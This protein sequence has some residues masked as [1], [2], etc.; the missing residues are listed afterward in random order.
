MR[1]RQLSIT[2]NNQNIELVF[3]RA[4]LSVSLRVFSRLF[5]HICRH[6]FNWGPLCRKQ[7]TNGSRIRCKRR[8]RP[9]FSVLGGFTCLLTQMQRSCGHRPEETVPIRKRRLPRVSPPQKTGTKPK[10]ST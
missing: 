9:L 2:L 4:R 7:C 10:L 5:C 1:T 6:S 8:Q 3:E